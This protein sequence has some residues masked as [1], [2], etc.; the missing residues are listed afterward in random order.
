M[1]KNF[2][3][4]IIILFLFLF[5][6][7]YCSNNNNLL[8][9]DKICPNKNKK[10]LFSIN[11]NN[12]ISPKIPTSFPGNAIFNNYRY[13][14]LIFTIP[15]TQI[16]KYFYLEAYD[17]SNNETIISNGDCYFINVGEKTE[18]EIRIYKKL[19]SNS[20]IRFGFFGITENFTMMVKLEFTLNTFLFLIDIPLTNKNSLY[21]SSV[22]PSENETNIENEKNIEQKN[23]EKLCKE[24]CFKIMQRIFKTYLNINLFE[25]SFYSSIEIPVSPFF[26]VT[27]EYSVGWELTTENTFKP[28]I[29]VLSET[30]VIDGKIDSHYDKL[31][32]NE[33][34]NKKNNVIKII[35][36]Y[37]KKILNIVLEFIKETKY[38]TLTIST[39]SDNSIAVFTLK[40]YKE[41]TKNINYEIQIKIQ[42]NN[43]NIKNLAKFASIKIKSFLS[44]MIE[45]KV[46]SYF[47]K[48][49]FI[50]GIF[51][52]LKI[53]NPELDNY[54]QSLPLFDNNKINSVSIALQSILQG[55]DDKLN[56]LGVN[57]TELGAK[58][59]NMKY[60][61]NSGIYYADFDCWQKIFG[62]NKIYDIIFN[63]G[64]SMETNNEGNFTYNNE[65]YIFWAWK[66]DYINLGAG[67]ELGIYY[68]GL[69]KDFSHWKVDK[70]LVMSMSLNLSHKTHGNIVKNWNNNGKETWW[71]N[72]FA[73]KYKK[74]KAQ[75]LTANFIVEFKD[76]NMFNEFA[77]TERK[78]WTYD[79]NKNI[80]TLNL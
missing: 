74:V 57:T 58:F 42:F 19:I 32:F 50:F 80:A 73:P 29:N 28:E 78:G 25:N 18:Y 67:A 62:M 56:S 65:N 26:L 66:G 49:F 61:N 38:F 70:S 71:I 21:K 23:R 47:D 31:Y 54:M 30:T 52:I 4:F 7:I 6:H 45:K 72:A 12:S 43:L 16:Q 51:D 35:E 79:K 69:E 59:L 15:T 8:D 36:L 1:K 9:S 77:K 13:I 11:Y 14:Y 20:Y 68:G 5:Y 22:F 46:N 3:T 2:N 37:N 60:D 63:L 24:L 55:T 76:K 75:D 41:R 17:I 39:N 53:I 10:C 48:I 64:S 33:T 44:E 34:I 27:V 40:N